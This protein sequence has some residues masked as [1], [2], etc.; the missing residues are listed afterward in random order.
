MAEP[1][2]TRAGATP[3]YW[4]FVAGRNRPASAPDFSA[5][6]PTCCGWIR[7]EG[8]GGGDPGD[9]ISVLGRA[10]FRLYR[11]HNFMGAGN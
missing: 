2:T 1:L 9:I 11:L 5:Q 10:L 3:T 4:D 8:F 6:V 7:A